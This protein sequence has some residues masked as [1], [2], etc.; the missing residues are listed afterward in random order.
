MAQSKRK[1]KLAKQNKEEGKKV[2]MI[3]L[4]ITVVVLFLLYLSFKAMG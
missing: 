3:T 4:G 1:K 2:L